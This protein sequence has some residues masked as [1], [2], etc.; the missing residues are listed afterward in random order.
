MSGLNKLVEQIKSSAKNAAD[1]RLQEAKLQAE[2]VL[3][4]AEK[5]A[6][7]ESERILQEAEI[8]AADGMERSK[9][10]AALQKRRAILS[11][12]QQMIEET[13]QK[14]R[15][16]LQAMPADEYFD[17]I[18]KMVSRYALPQSGHM[19]LS[20]QDLNRLPVDFEQRLN[21]EILP[22]GGSLTISSENRH[23]DGGFVL[24]YG[25]VE[26]NCAFEAI[27]S[28]KY[29]ILQDKIHEFLFT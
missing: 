26:E 20:Q 17:L 5:N 1:A 28:S 2:S 18:G 7:K 19:I 11:A 13:I 29:D 15:N 3:Q 10:T 12:K 25:D 22:K 23:I 14:A 9:S 24:V 4:Q 21:Q 8:R 27:F 16:T 6:K